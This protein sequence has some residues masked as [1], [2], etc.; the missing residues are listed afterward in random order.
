MYS[1]P[2]DL[3]DMFGLRFWKL[4]NGKWETDMLSTER[5]IQ[6]Q[7]NRAELQH[8]VSSVQ[9]TR[10]EVTWPAAY[11]SRYCSIY[12]YTKSLPDFTK[13]F[14]RKCWP[15]NKMWQ[16]LTLERQTISQSLKKWRR[17]WTMMHSIIQ[18][19]SSNIWTHHCSY[20]SFRSVTIVLRRI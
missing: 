10:N 6:T 1:P 13:L 19:F 11:G 5:P 12:L 8:L 3:P 14:C 2:R 17:R 7:L 4:K 9:C 15:V 20:D 18:M 16:F